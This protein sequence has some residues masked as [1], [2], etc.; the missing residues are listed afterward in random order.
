MLGTRAANMEKRRS[1]ILE[2]ARK[3]L[4]A[5]GF[6][7]LNLRELADISGITVPTI[8]NLI[9]NKAEVLKALVMGA[10]ATFEVSLEDKLPCRTEELPA[11]MMSTFAQMMG[12]DEA[13]Y[14]ATVLASERLELEPEGRYRYGF[15]HNP[16]RKLS[17]KLCQDAKE[18]GLLRGDIDSAVLVEQMIANHQ[19]ALRDWA[20]HAISLDQLRRQALRGFYIALA[21]DA[22]DDFHE[23]IVA[24]LMEL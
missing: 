23:S 1:R 14:R 12:Q 6:D 10:F 15:E 7:A 5:G 17:D 13:Y 2:Q 20:H 8:Y 3:M 16:L 19:M 22:G 21:A 4:A 9:G 24:Q 11:V 18:E